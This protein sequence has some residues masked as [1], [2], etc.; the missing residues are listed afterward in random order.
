M[1]SEQ[2]LH[3]MNEPLRFVIGNS[4]EVMNK[5]LYHIDLKQR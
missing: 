1:N 4:P 5:Y 2:N 3:L